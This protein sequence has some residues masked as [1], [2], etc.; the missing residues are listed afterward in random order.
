MQMK[1]LGVAAAGLLLTACAAAYP[2]LAQFN[3]PPPDTSDEVGQALQAATVLQK[4][5]SE[6]YKSTAKWQ[7]LSQLPIIG[8]AAI[9]AWILLN[10]HADAAQKAGKVGIAT[11]AYSAGR[12]QL[13]AAGMPDAYLAGY[14]ALTCVLAEGPTFSG[15]GAQKRNEKFQSQIGGLEDQIALVNE[16]RNWQANPKKIKGQG[17]ALK[18]A[19]AVA[20]Q[21]ITNARTAEAAS[22]KQLG[23][24]NAAPATFRNAVSSVS[25]TVASKGRVRPA[26]DFGSLRDQ[27]ASVEGG[28]SNKSGGNQELYFRPGGPVV[29]DDPKEIIPELMTVTNALT[30]LTTRLTGATPDYLASLSTV[31]DCAKKM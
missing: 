7:D 28:G 21:A 27:M 15:A 3:L 18:A 5:Y 8:G 1:S 4:A 9:A 25:V 12:G 23:A 2:D 17:D 24:W 16:V 6:G 26:V 10:K 20:D 19:Y 13:M 11:T 31:Q 30:T 22:L 29:S 14:G